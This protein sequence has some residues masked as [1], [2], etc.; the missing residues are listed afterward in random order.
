MLLT[1]T[2]T[3]QPATDLGYLL[4]K[5]PARLHS[6]TQSYGVAHVFY[7]E[8]RH[9]RCTAALF[10]EVDPVGLVRHRR[11]P[12]GDTGLL[13]Q[14]VN[15][16]PYAASSLLSVAIADTFGSALN[17]RSNDRPE[18]A[19]LPIPLEIS[20][21]AVP[22]RG[23]EQFLRSLFEPLGYDVEATRMELDERF[24][25]WGESQYY[26][27]R[28]S[29]TATLQSVLTHLYVLIPVLDNK[30]HYWVGDAEVDK[31]LRHGE[32]W[33]NAHPQRD[34]IVR[35]Y[36]KFKRSLTDRALERLVEADGGDAEAIDEEAETT[37]R[38][39]EREQAL[40][41]S[42]SLNDQ[43]IA[44]VRDTVDSLGAS[45][46]IDLGCGEGK[47]VKALLSLKSLTRITGVD[48]SHRVLEMAEERLNM[49]RLPKA[50][51]DKLTLLHGS[52]M[53]RDARFDGYDAA[54]IIEVI[55][56]L[57]PPRLAAFE[58]VVFEYAR[59]KSVVLTT[60]N[61]E[62]NVKFPS[63]PAG[64]FRHDDHRFEWTRAEFESWATALA[65]RHGYTVRFQPVGEV[66]P[67]LGPPTQMAVF[68]KQ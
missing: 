3:H 36:L 49:D 67:E 28:L 66:D 12:A 55:E 24:P 27:V 10:V 59:P 63:L 5:N 30:K 2:T 61:R 17:G 8:A 58:R 37:S 38:G 47:L 46:V 14:Y 9:D 32:P 65:A 6:R 29:I 42:V 31:L 68:T 13:D 53:Y 16:R 35:R 41:K 57:D 15:D 40:E 48:V 23:G 56:H 20:L 1:I 21:P 22:S 39:G 51:A 33:L 64:Q 4:H 18:L 45:T 43:R 62:Y 60:P 52:L 54:T 44:M 19:V 50:V 11:G 25:A 7:P 26:G 34:L